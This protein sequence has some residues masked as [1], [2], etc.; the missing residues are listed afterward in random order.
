[1]APPAERGAEIFDLKRRMHGKEVG[2]HRIGLLGLQ[3]ARAVHQETTGGHR[4]GHACQ[5]LAL[6]AGGSLQIFRP[7]APL[8]LGPSADG[9]QAGAWGVQKDP[10]KVVA[11]LRAGTPRIAE[12]RLHA[13]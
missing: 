12:L 10:G 13:G 5:E 9:P 8:D 1:V 4:I 3:A 7:A 2:H 6:Q 11:R